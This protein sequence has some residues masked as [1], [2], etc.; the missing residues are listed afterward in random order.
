MGTWELIIVLPSLVFENF[1]IK[2]RKEKEAA[3]LQITG[4]LLRGITANY[5]EV[6]CLSQ[7]P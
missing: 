7:N 3:G 1:Q 2:K 5:I 6:T 4:L